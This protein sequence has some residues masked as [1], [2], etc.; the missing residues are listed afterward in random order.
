MEIEINSLK[1]IK[2]EY[3]LYLLLPKDGSFLG[4]EPYKT[5]YMLFVE[6]FDKVYKCYIAS[7]LHQVNSQFTL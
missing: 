2:D 5:K 3:S 4:Q 6:I 1:K 7:F